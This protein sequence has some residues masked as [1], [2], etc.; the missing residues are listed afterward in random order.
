MGAIRRMKQGSRL[1][2]MALVQECL[3]APSILDLEAGVA[4]ALAR[5]SIPIASDQPIAL[6]VGSRGIAMLANIVRAAADWVREQG[7]RPFIVPAM[8]SH[9][10]ATSE[11][12]RAVLASYGITEAAMGCPIES[13][14]EP[15]S[16]PQEESPI[17]VFLDRHVFESAGAIVINRIKP[18][19]DYHGPYESGLM[20]MIAIGLGKHAQALAIH[21]HGVHGLLEFMPRVAKRIIQTGKI[22]GGLGIVEN[23]LDQP[24]HIEA[25]AASDIAEREPELLM[26]AAKAMPELPSSDIDL[27][28][29]DYMGKNISGVGMDP[30]IIGRMRVAGQPEPD[31]P[32][33]RLI[34]VRD[35]TSESHGNALGVGLADLC[36]RRLFDQIDFQVMNEN[37]HASTF[38][39]RGKIP[40]IAE[41][42]SAAVELALRGLWEPDPSRLAIV[43]IHNTLHLDK[44]L[45]SPA[46]LA[47]ACPNPRRMLVSEGHDLFDDHLL[48]A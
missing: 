33:I 26:K 48:F 25:M 44:L 42:E 20:K 9:G 12:Q 8:G 23:A 7:G 29:V 11:G 39:E 14:I 15:V 6:A 46:A 16:L 10:G 45:M 47:R 30:N 13:K 2:L 28:I 38:L 32:R 40:V 18:H 5:S 19:T 4:E 22:L 37:L 31:S 17:P 21:Q 43:R 35:L 27:L 34:F 41:N 24:M 3:Q 36:T 1:P